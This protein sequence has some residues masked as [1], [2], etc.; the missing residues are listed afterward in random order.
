MFQ[1]PKATA[2]REI[3]RSVEH[4]RLAHSRPRAAC[5]HLK[6]AKALGLNISLQLEQRADEVIE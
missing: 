6:T 5:G 4:Q 3:A 2:H 1:T